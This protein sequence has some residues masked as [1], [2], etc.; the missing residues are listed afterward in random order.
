MI[1]WFPDRAHQFCVWYISLETGCNSIRRSSLW[2]S[3]IKSR[4][5]WQGG[6]KAPS[7]LA[8]RRLDTAPEGK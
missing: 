1:P 3:D 4:V 7:A 6:A 5:P 2:R 8:E